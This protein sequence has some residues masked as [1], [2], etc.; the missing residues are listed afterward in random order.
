MGGPDQ[1]LVLWNSPLNQLLDRVRHIKS[2]GLALADVTLAFKVLAFSV[3][4]FT[5]QLAKPNGLLIKQVEI[6]MDIVT[7]SPRYSLGK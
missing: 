1:S 7:S 2:L 5:F 4:S 3:L 6:A